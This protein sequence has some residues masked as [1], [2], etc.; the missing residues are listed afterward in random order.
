[1]WNLAQNDSSYFYIHYIDTTNSKNSITA[2][3]SLN[4]LTRL[5]FHVKPSALSVSQFHSK[6]MDFTPASFISIKAIKLNKGDKNVQ[7]L[8]FNDCLQWHR[9]DPLNIVTI[10][11]PW[12][13]PSIVW[14][15]RCS[16]Q[17]SDTFQQV[18]CWPILSVSF[19]VFIPKLLKCCYS[20]KYL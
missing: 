1:M 15:T 8:F 6:W 11:R 12:S 17:T 7:H 18:S 13:K 2:N 16:V 10:M 5:C 14:R 3:L 4:I 9:C 19:I 20:I